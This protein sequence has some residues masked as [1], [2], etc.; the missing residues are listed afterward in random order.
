MRSLVT[1][2]THRALITVQSNGEG[3]LDAAVADLIDLV[4]RFCG[5]EG[6]AAIADHRQPVVTIG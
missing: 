1:P 2:L 6:R 4:Q 3:D 5:G